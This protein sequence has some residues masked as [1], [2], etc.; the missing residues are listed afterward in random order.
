MSFNS[1]V[2]LIIW[3][4]Y[5]WE[6]GIGK[7]YHCVRIVN[8]FYI[9]WYYLMKLDMSVFC[10]YIV[11]MISSLAE[12]SLLGM[13]CPLTGELRLINLQSCYW[14]MYINICYFVDCRKTSLDKQLFCIIISFL[15]PLVC[16]FSF[17]NQT[18]LY[19]AGLVIGNP[20]VCFYHRKFLFILQ[21][22]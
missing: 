1:N 6:W 10:T 19:R 3:P 17:L 7:Y 11:T 2:S 5:C 12:H 18:T 14:D 21:M 9:I 15:G 8:W 22:Y 13:K 16:F 4:V 20:L